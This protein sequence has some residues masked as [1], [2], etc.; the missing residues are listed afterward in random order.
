M[1]FLARGVINWECGGGNNYLLEC[2]AALRVCLC[3]Q[4]EYTREALCQNTKKTSD[5]G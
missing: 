2:N 4:T 3:L 1:N 5:I